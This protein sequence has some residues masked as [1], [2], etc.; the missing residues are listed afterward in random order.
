MNLFL[1]LTALGLT[2][3][4]VTCLIAVKV[5]PPKPVSIEAPIPVPMT[6]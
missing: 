2:V 1:W 6:P 3:L 5:S 4:N